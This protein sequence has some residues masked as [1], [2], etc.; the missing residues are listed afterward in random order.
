MIESVK[1]NN[2]KEIMSLFDPNQGDLKPEVNAKD[3]NSWSALHYSCLNGNYEIV[4]FLLKND[5]NIEITTNTKQTP[6]MVASQK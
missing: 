1:N 6:L 4:L 3:I 2:I 5:A